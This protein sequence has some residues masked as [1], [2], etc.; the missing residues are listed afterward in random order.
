VFAYVG[1]ENAREIS[2]HWLRRG[3][4]YWLLNNGVSMETVSRI[5]A[6]SS[7]KMTERIYAKL[8]PKTI[9][10]DVIDHIENA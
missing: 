2:S 1:V 8:L 3:C 5:L 7:I 9:V 4:G 6:H 10:N